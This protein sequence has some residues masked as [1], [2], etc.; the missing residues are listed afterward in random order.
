[1]N[2]L[3]LWAVFM[4]GPSGPPMPLHHYRPVVWASQE[5]CET[6]IMTLLNNGG[7]IITDPAYHLECVAVP[8]LSGD[9]A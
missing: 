4:F 6:E 8:D 5:K 3:V 1:M 2:V 7:V 9:P